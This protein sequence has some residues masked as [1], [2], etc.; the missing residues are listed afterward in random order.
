M[1]WFFYGFTLYLLCLAAPLFSQ[2]PLIPEIAGSIETY[3]GREMTLVLRLSYVD[4]V[5][6]KI[7]FYD[8]KNNSI[9]FDISPEAMKKLNAGDFM[10]LHEGLEYRVVM[11]VRDR[12]AGGGL[13]ADL[14]SFR[15][16]LV[17][18][19]P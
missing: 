11:L 14:K 6:Q 4:R 18:K 10:N 13:V 17:E 8:R 3:K 7:V 2:D 15:P 19:L 9:E 12:G 1:K 5:F 16:S